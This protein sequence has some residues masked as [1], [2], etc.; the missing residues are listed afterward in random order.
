MPEGGNPYESV[1]AFFDEVYRLYERYWWQRDTRYST[2]PADHAQSLITLHLLEALKTRKPGRALDTGAG[3]GTDAIRLALMGYEVDA[4]EGS[5]VGCEKIEQFAR[6]VGVPLNIINDDVNNFKPSES[7]NVIV[8]NGILHY[9]EDQAGLIQRLQDATALNGLNAVSLWTARTPVPECHRIVDTYVDGSSDT[10]DDWTVMRMYK[11]W[12][13]LGQWEEE[14]KPETGHP[15][16]G[17]HS[18]SFLKFISE[19]QD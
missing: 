8:C 5:S 18:H 7:Y 12:H 11:H 1:I 15:G 19:K 10:R 16:F 2:D 9:I 17:P 4:V 14:N 6:Q 3:E 13:N